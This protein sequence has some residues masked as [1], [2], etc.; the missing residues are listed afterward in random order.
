MAPRGP[1]AAA[2]GIG[3]GGAGGA[4]AGAEPSRPEFAVQMEERVGGGAG[5]GRGGG[6]R[7]GAWG[8]ATGSLHV[9]LGGAAV[10]SPCRCSASVPSSAGPWPCRTQVRRTNAVAALLFNRWSMLEAV[11]FSLRKYASLCDWQTNASIPDGYE[12]VR[13]GCCCCRCCCVRLGGVAASPAHAPCTRACAQVS[14]SYG[15]EWLPSKL[16]HQVA[17]AHREHRRREEPD[18]SD[19]TTEAGHQGQPGGAA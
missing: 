12:Q 7:C 5:P 10:R 17:R 14:F 18:V 15:P 6:A 11:A 13:G 19:S 8:S 16:R 1:E 3:E 2:P 9:L 4:S